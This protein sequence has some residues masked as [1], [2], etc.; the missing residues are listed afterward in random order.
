MLAI[1]PVIVLADDKSQLHPE[2]TLLPTCHPIPLALPD[3]TK[4]FKSKNSLLSVSLARRH[5]L[6]AQTLCENNG[7]LEVF[8]ALEGAGLMVESFKVSPGSVQDTPLVIWI[9]CL[10]G[11]SRRQTDLQLP[12]CTINCLLE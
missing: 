11:F 10:P 2:T 12:P 3:L 1:F 9:P 7:P 4:T 5:P 8:E 6:F